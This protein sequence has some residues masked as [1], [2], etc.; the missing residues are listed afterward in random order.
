M[1]EFFGKMCTIPVNDGFADG[2]L[3]KISEADFSGKNIKFNE[4]KP[5]GMLRKIFVRNS[6]GHSYYGYLQRT[7]LV[8]IL[9][10]LEKT[11]LNLEE[12]DTNDVIAFPSAR[13]RISSILIS[14]NRFHANGKYV[15]ITIATDENSSFDIVVEYDKLCQTLKMSSKKS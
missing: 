12:L 8:R 5:R 3:F 14:T 6:E 11:K 4:E 2:N 13:C 9:S 1:P 15:L 7:D 10:N